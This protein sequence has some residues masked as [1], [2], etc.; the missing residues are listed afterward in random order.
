MAEAEPKSILDNIEEGIKEYWQWILAAIIVWLI[1]VF[2]LQ[3]AE[4]E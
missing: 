1:F 2:N 3:Y 4:A